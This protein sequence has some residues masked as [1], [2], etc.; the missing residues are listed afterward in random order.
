MHQ[1]AWNRMHRD[2]SGEEEWTY[3]KL[4]SCKELGSLARFKKYFWVWPCHLNFVGTCESMM[5]HSVLISLMHMPSM[6]RMHFLDY[7]IIN[8]FGQI[9]VYA[10]LRY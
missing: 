3:P 10:Y 7:I 2:W 1:R 8:F 6:T 5:T 4:P 9:L